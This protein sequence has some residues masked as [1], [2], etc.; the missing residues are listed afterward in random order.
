M[1]KLKADY[2]TYYLLPNRNKF[3]IWYDCVWTES[4]LTWSVKLPS[5]S[6]IYMDAPVGIINIVVIHY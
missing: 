1:R 5:T 3:K 2:L 4:I 6:A